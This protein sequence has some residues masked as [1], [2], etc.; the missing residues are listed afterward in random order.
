MDPG[1]APTSNAVHPLKE[2]PSFT[3]SNNDV[4]YIS[5]TSFVTSSPPPSAGDTWNR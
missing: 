3:Y 2:C 4:L 1:P 5:F